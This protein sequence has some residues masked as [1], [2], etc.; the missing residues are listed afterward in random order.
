MVMEKESTYLTFH[1]KNMVAT[2]GNI[3]L[4]YIL[5]Y[6]IDVGLVLL[7]LTLTYFTPSLVFL[8]LTLNK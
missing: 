1:L 8:L 5:P 6:V 3:T 4:H 2:L 7:L